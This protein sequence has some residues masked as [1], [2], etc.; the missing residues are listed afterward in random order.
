MRLWS[1]HPQYLDPKG[2]VALW[3][4]GL[5]AQHVL[6]GKTKGYRN[7]PQLIR[8]K[9]ASDP[10]TTIATYLQFVV[11]EAES[12]SYRFDRTKIAKGK[13]CTAIR[14]TEKQI[15]YEF[16]HLLKKLEQRDLHRYIKLKRISRSRIEP[17]PL[18]R[19]VPGEIEEW[20]RI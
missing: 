1:L 5:L 10:I 2:L 6:L 12:R 11:D 8:F 16:K 18:F 20:E 17:H 9:A 15:V 13:G 4:E 7:H 19:V 3:R 14:V